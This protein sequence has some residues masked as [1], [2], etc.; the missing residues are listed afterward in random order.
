MWINVYRGI[1]GRCD[2]F[3]EDSFINNSTSV[4]SYGPNDFSN[5]MNSG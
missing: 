4:G 1:I 5:D 2:V 3:N